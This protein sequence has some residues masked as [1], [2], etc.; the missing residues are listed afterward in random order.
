[1]NDDGFVRMLVDRV[2]DMLG[3][4]YTLRIDHLI[5][6]NDTSRDALTI[7]KAGENVSPAIHLD[8]YY[9]KYQ[10]GMSL[11]EICR[12]LVECYRRSGPHTLDVEF[13]QDWGTVRDQVVCRLVGRERN[14][15]RLDDIFYTPYLD[16]AVIY[17]YMFPSQD[18]F[19]A[20]MALKRKLVKGWGVDPEEIDRTASS[21]TWR[22]MPP[23][24]MS[25]DRMMKRLLHREQPEEDE[26]EE[27][28]LLYVLTNDSQMGGAYWIREA[29]VLE[30]IAKQV[31][32]GFLVLPSSI[33]ECMIV[34]ADVAQ[35]TEVVRN[36]V[37]EI[38]RLYVSA[39]DVLTDSVY[40]YE[41]STG[42][43]LVP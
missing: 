5:R 19:T 28:E 31:G 9:Q 3:P 6:N 23:C 18:S 13:L 37:R 25:M 36:M 17:Y 4:G 11:D 42:L 12:E 20:G 1:M 2:Q 22:R 21:N 26:A 30:D 7:L 34:P 24:F 8:W 35:E 27:K 33:H 32:D 38:N 39:E 29:K 41:K 14:R 16:M 40:R 10:E 15:K 43:Q